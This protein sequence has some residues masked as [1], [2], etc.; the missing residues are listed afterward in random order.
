MTKHKRKIK[1][2]RIL[3]LIV[4]LMAVLWLLLYGAV[5]AALAGMN[6]AE[7]ISSETAGISEQVQSDLA[8]YPIENIVLFGM[9]HDGEVGSDSMNRSDAIKIISI[10]QLT[11]K[12]RLTSVQ[13]D[14]LIWIPDPVNDF[15][16]WNHAYWWGGA[17]LAVK[18]LNVNLDLDITK[19]IS[20]SFDALEQLVELTG[21]V[22]IELTEA[23]VWDM[24]YNRPAGIPDNGPGVYHL[25]GAQALAYCRIRSVDNDYNRMNRQNVIMKAV[26]SALKKKN[27]VE[28]V[29]IARGVLPYI[30]TNLSNADV[31]S[32]LIRLI[33]AD[34]DHIDTYEVPSGEWGDVQTV[35][36]YGGY[37]PL[38]KLNSYSGMIRGLHE[39]I[40][41]DRN[42]QVSDQALEIEQKIYSTFN[43]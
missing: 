30:E 4:C 1:P 12:I 8:K 7:A 31:A 39:F 34:P 19:Y 42:Y 26:A 2:F 3:F 16:K 21:G 38:Y 15:S 6:H 36:S 37:Y 29:R 9:D 43:W 22:D 35:V 24:V 41:G 10:N 40:Y 14:T 23:E 13:R 27:P 33:T 18:T 28:M 5:S 25:N 20:F 11:G 32:Y 17:E